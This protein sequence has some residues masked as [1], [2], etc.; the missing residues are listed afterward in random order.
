MRWINSIASYLGRRLASAGAVSLILVAALPVRAQ[1]SYSATVLYPVN[2]PSGFDSQDVYSSVAGQSVGNAFESEYNYSGHAFLWSAPSGSVTDLNPTPLGF[3]SSLAEATNGPQQV[4]Y[5]FTP[6]YPL[7]HALLW[8][9]SAAS[10]IDLNPP[11]FGSSSAVGMDA[12]QQVGGGMPISS[13]TGFAH[14][15][16]WSGTA[17]SAVD[18][19][20]TGYAGSG[21]LAVSGDQQVGSAILNFPLAPDNQDQAFL[22]SGTAASAV[23]L[24]PPGFN[25]S[26]ADGT[27][28]S[29]QVGY[30]DDTTTGG[31]EHALLWNGNAASAVD[32]N[33]SGFIRS[34]AVA[35]NGI[36][37][38]GY[39]YTT[40]N[41][42]YRQALLWSGTAA[43]AIDLQSL[44]P[45]SGGW[46]VSDTYS[47]DA[48]GNVFGSAYGAYNGLAGEFAVEWSPVPEPGT[49]TLLV[50]TATGLL[51]RRRRSPSHG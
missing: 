45:A 41:G 28:G 30:G 35:T 37:Q 9:G 33:P 24:D 17:A 39:G 21:A 46:S 2:A 44:L 14:A 31:I 29:Q 36:E 34:Y 25:Q 3:T 18:L 8:S 47:I 5:G 13:S 40:P 4:G 27:N 10:A 49:F 7:G 26:I 43:S 16:L 20:P 1:V 42:G 12:T 15:L 50:V 32:L 11:G 51:M 23:D 6:E 22:W 48:E 38:V 19:N